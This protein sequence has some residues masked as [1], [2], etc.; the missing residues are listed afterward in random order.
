MIPVLQLAEQRWKGFR[1]EWSSDGF[2]ACLCDVFW[3]YS[4]WCFTFASAGWLAKRV[5]VSVLLSSADAAAVFQLTWNL[6]TCYCGEEGGGGGVELQ[7][8]D[9][10][11]DYDDYDRAGS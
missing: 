9:F 5:S 1:P 2:K 10:F 6:A 11:I 3:T 8:V 4:E 7:K